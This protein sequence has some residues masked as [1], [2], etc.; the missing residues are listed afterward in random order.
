MKYLSNRLSAAMWS[1]VLLLWLILGIGALAAGGTAIALGRFI[2]GNIRT[3]L[4]SQQISFSP[5][6]KLSDEE[7]AIPG[8]VENAGLPLTTGNQA[9]VWSQLM[10]LH[11]NEAADAAGYPGATYATIGAKQ[12]EL[13]AAVQAA[14]DA[15]DQTALDK[16]NADLTTVNNL[17]NTMLTASNLRGNLL[18]A[19][20]WD[21][22]ATGASVTGTI[23]LVLGLLFFGLFVF[24][25]RLGHLP[26]PETQAAVQG[27]AAAK[28]A[29]A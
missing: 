23:I 16:A 22:V 20:G 17:R 5:V 27:Q 10:A 6:D 13:K 4:A 18:S 28:V 14:T 12:R 7:K 15:N 26:T 11:V 2:Q 3:E 25:L 19:Y 8:I 24:E 29:T 9:F 1:R 21:N